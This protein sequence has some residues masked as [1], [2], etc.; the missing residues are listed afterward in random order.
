MVELRL[1]L[2][3]PLMIYYEILLILLRNR[4]YFILFLFSELANFNLKTKFTSFMLVLDKEKI[5]F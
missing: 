2:D 4:F 1:S 5:N 3:I